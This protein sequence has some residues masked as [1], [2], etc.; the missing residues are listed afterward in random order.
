MYYMQDNNKKKLSIEEQ[1]ADF[2]E[3]NIKFELY[4]EEEAKK[5][6]KYNNYFFKLKSYAHNYSK[7]SKVE[8]RHKYV[9]LDFAY[10]VELST[11]DMYFRRVIVGLCLDIEHVLKTRLMYDITKNDD[12]DGYNIVRNYVKNDYMVLAGLYKNIGNSATTELIEKFHE[13]EDKIPV[14]SFIETLSFGRFIE[15]YQYYYGTYGGASYSSYL[16]SI[17]FLRNA[18]AHNTCLLNSLRRPYAIKINKNKDIMDCLDKSKRFTTSFKTKMAN[19]VIHDFVVLLF[20]YY[21]ILNTSANRSMR[22]KGMGEVNKLFFET[23]LRKKVFFEKN[24]V[25]IEDYKFVCQVIKYLES[26]RNNSVLKIG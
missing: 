23:M 12:E 16:G 3:K 22:E 7:Y 13:D 6:L 25:L 18:A 14:W 24:D 8:L 5:F 1:I 20:V 10:L 11:L 15:L 2:K 21:D 17:K 4:P 26:R 9:N 19:P